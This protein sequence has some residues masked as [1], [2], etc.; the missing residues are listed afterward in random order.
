MGLHMGSGCATVVPMSAQQQV[1]EWIIE[2]DM[3]E[4][5]GFTSEADAR[6]YQRAHR[7]TGS[8]VSQIA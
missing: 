2:W 1:T 4:Y 5:A 6:A 3:G 7:M 8:V